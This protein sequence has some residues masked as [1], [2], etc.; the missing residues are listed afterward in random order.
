[1]RFLSTI[2]PRRL[3]RLL[4]KKVE[5]EK[6]IRERLSAVRMMV[7]VLASRSREEYIECI[8][9][10]QRFDKESLVSVLKLF[11]DCEKSERG[12]LALQMIDRGKHVSE[13]VFCSVD[14]QLLWQVTR[15]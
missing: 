13:P 14:D 15:G 1:M 2:P 5:T 3:L 7:R 10:H 4:L 11:L 6:A 9:Q 12:L 8:Q